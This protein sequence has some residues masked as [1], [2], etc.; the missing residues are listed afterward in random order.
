M[1]FEPL[2]IARQGV[3]SLTIDKNRRIRLSSSALKDLAI[4]PFTPVI[5]SVDVEN[6]RVGIVKQ[7]LAKIPN[8]STVRSDKRGYLGV[9]AGKMAISKLALADADLPAKFNYVGKVDSG[10]VFWHAFELSR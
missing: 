7:D 6:K 2:Q 5:V 1:P 8:A 9:A 4:T 3:I 10:P